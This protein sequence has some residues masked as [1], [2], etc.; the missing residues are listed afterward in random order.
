MA[1]SRE[2]HLRLSAETS[3]DPKLLGIAKQVDVPFA[4]VLGL[5]THI[6]CRA[7]KSDKPGTFTDTPTELG[8]MLGLDLPVVE[9]I[10]AA[11]EF[12]R[13]NLIDGNRICKWDKHQKGMNS[14]ADRVARYRE[15]KQL[16]TSLIAPPKIQQKQQLKDNV[17]LHRT[18]NPE[19]KAAK[20]LGTKI[21]KERGVFE[22]LQFNQMTSP[23]TDLF[24]MGIPSDYIEEHINIIWDRKEL[25]RDIPTNF[26]YYASAIKSLWKQSQSSEGSLNVK[27]HSNS[28]KSR[29][30]GEDIQGRREA[31]FEHLGFASEM[32]NR[33]A[34]TG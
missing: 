16:E 32:D 15:K 7:R 30:T 28:G 17:T 3:N 26:Q 10:L 6:L 13:R 14:S 9:E 29:T 31:I 22:T 4:V 11:L 33:R 1:A 19:T 34:S 5:W 21:M 2:L 12:H 20:E 18:V 23:L 8:Y 24:K 27:Q 25:Q